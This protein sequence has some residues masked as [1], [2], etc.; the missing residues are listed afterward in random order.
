MIKSRTEDLQE[1]QVSNLNENFTY[2]KNLDANTSSPA[3]RWRPPL[4]SLSIEYGPAPRCPTH[5]QVLARSG[6]GTLLAFPFEA[7]W[8]HSFGS[9]LAF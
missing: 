5:T 2:V 6:E 8:K 3:G 1:V 9:L 7:R 4:R